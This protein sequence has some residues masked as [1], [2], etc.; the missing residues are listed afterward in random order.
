MST[1]AGT[2][3]IGQGKYKRDFGPIDPTLETI[4]HSRAYLHHLY[5]VKERPLWR[6]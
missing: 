4:G 1:R 6:P 3:H 5:R 2:I